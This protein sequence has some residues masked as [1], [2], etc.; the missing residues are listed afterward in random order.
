[1]SSILLGSALLVLV[2]VSVV[3]ILSVLAKDMS[4]VDIAWGL[5]FAAL[6]IF[7]WVRW[8]PAS[9]RSFL[10][11]Y[12]ILIWGLRLAVFLAIRN[13]RKGEDPRYA[14]WRHDWGKNTWWISYF[15]VFLL[16]G[17][18]MLM[19]SMPLHVTTAAGK[20]MGSLTD[21]AGTLLWLGGFLFESIADWQLYRFKKDPANKGMVMDKGLWKYSRH[22]NYFGESLIWWGIF[23]VAFGAGTAYLSVIG[24]VLITFLLLRVSGVTLLEQRYEGND[25]YA[26]Y[27]RRT[28]AFIPRPPKRQ[29]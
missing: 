16:Q 10:V 9:P 26:D 13:L 6:V 2:F 1:M 5:G 27:K 12:L 8:A 7:Q 4:I 21:F 23:L 20:S 22:P 24:P 19:I 14:A 17:A 11:G 18:L 28:S 29:V 3:W 25:K 15:K